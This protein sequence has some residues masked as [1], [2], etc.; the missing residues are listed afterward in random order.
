MTKKTKISQTLNKQ[1]KD[2]N[3]QMPKSVICWLQI[4]EIQAQESQLRTD[5]SQG[6]G[7]APA[8]HALLSQLALSSP[9]ETEQALSELLSAAAGSRCYTYLSS[10][11]LVLYVYHRQI[12]MT[13]VWFDRCLVLSRLHP[14]LVDTRYGEDLL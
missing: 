11:H 3:Q 6:D 8:V 5:S 9:E 10:S 4:E 14:S 12:D 2:Q 7:Q 1:N 13:A